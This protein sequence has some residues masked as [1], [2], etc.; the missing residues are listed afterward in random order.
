MHTNQNKDQSLEKKKKQR[1][2]DTHTC[3]LISRI[4]K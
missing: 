1:G 4:I 2:L 3:N